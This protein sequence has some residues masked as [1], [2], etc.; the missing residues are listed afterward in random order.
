[1]ARLTAC[2][3]RLVTCGDSL[4]MR[5]CAV[6]TQ[7]VGTAARLI[8]CPRLHNKLLARHAGTCAR[9]PLCTQ[10]AGRGGWT[11]LAREGPVGVLR[12]SLAVCAQP[13][14]DLPAAQRQRIR[15]TSGRRPVAGAEPAAAGQACLEGQAPH[16]LIAQGPGGR[17]QLEA[18]HD[19]SLHAEAVA[20]EGRLGVRSG[21]IAC[22]SVCCRHAQQRRR[23]PR[24]Q[25][26]GGGLGM[27]HAVKWH[28]RRKG[29]AEDRP[30]RC[31]QG[32]RAGPRMQE[33][34]QCQ[35]GAPA[36][37]AERLRPQ[38]EAQE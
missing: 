14:L 9:L 13:R 37:R 34:L 32:Q 22:V 7:G 5:L 36:L 27:T 21:W 18:L 3:T 4:R 1:M 2:L 35:D 20:L 15:P 26:H 16:R 10:P 19:A 23:L 8:I 28:A 30:H 38:W 31:S 25:R 29:R 6:A 24:A 17:G 11:C 12:C 33:A